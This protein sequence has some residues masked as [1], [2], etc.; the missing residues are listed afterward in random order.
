MTR[1]QNNFSYT[2]ALGIASNGYLR[3][4]ARLATTLATLA[5]ALFLFAGSARANTFLVTVTFDSGPGSLRQAI[6]D[7]NFNPGADE[8]HFK[9]PGSGVKTIPLL[10]ELPAITQ[11]LTIDGYTQLGSVKN[12]LEVGSNAVPLIELNGAGIG[13]NSSGQP[14]NGLLLNAPNCV[15]AGLI[16]NRFSGVGIFLQVYS[17]V[18]GHDALIYGCFIGT[19][20]S[21]TA[22][23]GNG[24]GIEIIGS[25][26]NIIGGIFF[27][28]RNVISGNTDSGINISNGGAA[29]KNNL[30]VENLIGTN[31]SGTAAVPNGTG[32][33][34]YQVVGANQI[35][36]AGGFGRNLISGN[37]EAG[38]ELN[39][40]DSTT[41]I[42]N[43]IGTNV[44]GNAKLGNQ[45][46]V[47][48]IGSSKNNKIGDVDAG[49]L[50]AGNSI[51]E[52]SLKGAPGP[53]NNQI[54]ANRIGTQADGISPLVNTADGITF[55]GNASHNQV[56]G[57]APGSGNIIAFNVSGVAALS[58]TGNL[59]KQNS[60]FSNTNLGIE[61]RGANG[62]NP[63]DLT[64]GD[65]GAN[66]LQN[67]PVIASALY[68]GGI[69]TVAGTLNSENG[70]SYR[71]EFFT[72]SQ[73]HASGYGEGAT[74]LGFTDVVTA[75]NNAS[76]SVNLPG[77][78]PN[79]FVT[80]TATDP[81]GN[82]SEFSQCKQVINFLPG[83]F[84]FSASN[85]GTA[86]N[87]N[88]TITVNRVGGSTGAATVKVATANG[89]AVA[90][91]DYTAVSGTIAFGDGVTSQSFAVAI[92]M[93]STYESNETI[94][95]TLS[96]PTG[97]AALGNP[98][99]AVLTITDDDPQ[100]K[101]SINDASI[102]EGNGGT[103]AIFA[104]S[105][106]NPGSEQITVDYA[107]TGAGTATSGDDYQ[108]ANG[109]LTFAPG[110]IS[111][112]LNVL[113]N[114]DTQ[115]EPDETFVVQLTNSNAGMG[116]SIG[117]GTIINDDA[118]PTPTPTPMP[119]PTPT[120]MPT[121][122]PTPT[123]TPEPTPM[124]TPTPQTFGTLQFSSGSYS[125]SEN[126]AQATVTVTRT[127]GVDG[128]V[129]VQYSSGGGTATIGGDYAATSGTLSWLD[130]DAS[131]KTFTIAVTNDALNE[132]DETVG[133]VLNN[134]SGGA[135]L[136]NLSSAT[137][138]IVD[139]DGPAA[140]SISDVS[141]AEGTSGTTNFNFDVTLSTASSQTITVDYLTLNG[142]AQAGSDYQAASGTLTF[143]PGETSKA[144]VVA[145]NG[146]TDVESDEAFVVGL[147]NPAS[148]TTSKSQ[149]TGTIVND[150]SNSPSPT[151]QFSQAA[152][153]VQEDLGWMTMTVTRGGDT[154]AAASVDYETVDGSGTQKAD[155][156]YAAGTLNFAAGEISKT[157]T[158]LVN[159][160]AY[161]EGNETFSVKLSNPAGAV[162]GQQSAASV[163]ITDDLPESATNPI[164]DAQSF[165]YTHY[166]DFLNREPD[167]AGLAFWTNQIASCGSDVK[168]IEEKRV[169]VSA[170]FF[171]S[172]EFQET[173]YLRYLLEKESFG[174]LPKYAEFMRDLQEVGRDVVVNS[175]GWEQKLRNNQQ[176][177]A[178]AWVKRPAFKAAYDAMSNAD[179]V[180]ALYAN[181]GVLPTQAERDSLVNA[182]DT[183][184]ESRA[185][186]LL[187]VAGN[188]AFRQKEN[189]SA[190]VLMQYFGYLRR[191]PAAAPD[192]DLTGYNF[193]L[194]KLNQFGGNYIDAEMIKA[195]I[196]S[197]E[198]RQRF[199]Q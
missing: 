63:N 88:M 45:S 163:N 179:Y 6:F 183:A 158:L 111:K 188:V 96:N 28:A 52:I 130:G 31:K 66:N 41:V 197:F 157:I 195:F 16:I 19:N 70:K 84:Q 137:I 98:T 71:I 50:I 87:G 83:A 91:T 123:P 153:A 185:R 100:P 25:G 147:S 82:T 108:P 145:V 39:Q 184:S 56:G 18:T 26:N 76:F 194:T 47:L 57:D 36:G 53:F 42:G 105:L 3:L 49:N 81:D 196:T 85:Y 126:G 138:T 159:E 59:I 65:I 122:T 178:E 125:I 193:W 131:D 78:S 109:T 139:D 10:T 149:G 33:L 142:S 135:S 144:V 77:T 22:A 140:I 121:P 127:G 34:L 191:D 165:V 155:F 101:V 75:A 136:G 103:T 55:G 143:A 21:G 114:G 162:L 119:T 90:G 182:L 7:A 104:V 1:P 64:D 95:L 69:T 97:G 15:I 186:I 133:L 115:E 107:T 134:P 164:D 35:G 177:F 148:A 62:P 118:A 132:L 146:D 198:Y 38:V 113:V 86:E 11:Q 170:S 9:I 173:G 51:A 175:P 68:S 152:Y 43:Y 93:D 166:H 192:S 29:A 151:I 160:D 73:C 117:T 8:I 169:N 190:F 141:L 189:N 23:A 120:P 80:A 180:N 27:A 72:N 154:S 94:N 24:T 187:E 17:G 199:A 92:T 172:I 89:T 5:V 40:S 13:L 167:P 44:N 106:S 174:S 168:C 150:D 54:L 74:Y 99:T 4:Y 37:N 12:T 32:I 61:L 2:S 58:G 20:A 46:G 79:Q 67:Y 48:L 102:V 14:A 156:E 116:K 176:L 30:I 171:L 129:S 124:P 161:L 128:A 181:A 112:P 110:E 60:I